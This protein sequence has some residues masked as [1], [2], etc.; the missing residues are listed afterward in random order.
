MHDESTVVLP[1][2]GGRWRRVRR[3]GLSVIGGFVLAVGGA[4]G[5][6]YL[7]WEVPDPQQVAA[8][9]QQSI[10]LKYADG[11]EMM[12]IVPESGN[13]IMIRDLGEVSGPMRQA[14]LAA[15]DASFYTNG[16]FDF[17][18]IVRAVFAQLT[19][20]AGGGSTLT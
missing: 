9:T 15:E 12:R 4:F 6:G 3:I 17:F 18:G 20:S 11:S 8:G 7:A 16:G 5:I 1:K 19:G 2:A 14:T 13:R 10:V